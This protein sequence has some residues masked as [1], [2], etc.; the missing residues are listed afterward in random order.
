MRFRKVQLRTLSCRITSDCRFSA[1]E[2]MAEIDEENG[3]A[4]HS[5]SV[6]TREA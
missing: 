1:V 2:S 4:I 5:R 6:F 3:K